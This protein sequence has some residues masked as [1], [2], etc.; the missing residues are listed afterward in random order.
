MR[1]GPFAFVDIPPQ[2][3]I[4]TNL[5]MATSTEDRL[6]VLVEDFVANVKALANEQALEAVSSALGGGT[7]GGTTT[8]RKKATGRKT[9]KKT[10]RKKTTRKKA[11]RRAKQ[12]PAQIEKLQGQVLD[13]VKKNPKSRLEQISAGLGIDSAKLKTPI[14]NML[15]EKALKKAGQ[16]RGTHYSAK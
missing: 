5:K 1:H 15:E 13:F 2:F 4:T 9:A 16:K 3:R 6:L 11:G 14:K 12:S 10:T 8:R 7:L